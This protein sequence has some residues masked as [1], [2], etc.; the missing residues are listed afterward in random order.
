MTTN[1]Q[2]EYVS[3]C[4]YLWSDGSKVYQ[5]DQLLPDGLPID[6]SD[7]CKP[8]AFSADELHIESESDGFW[9]MDRLG[10]YHRHPY[11]TESAAKQYLAY[12]KSGC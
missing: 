1:K 7:Y 3:D 2:M 9:V 5:E 12:L 6:Y 11:R 4:G 10:S 8:L